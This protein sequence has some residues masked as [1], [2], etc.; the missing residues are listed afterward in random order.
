MEL[1]IGAVALVCLP[2]FDNGPETLNVSSGFY[3]YFFGS[4]KMSE[5]AFL[6]QLGD[7]V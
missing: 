4:P 3:F 5:T 1:D 2:G 6:L 7:S